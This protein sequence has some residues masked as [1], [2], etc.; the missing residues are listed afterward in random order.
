MVAALFAHDEGDDDRALQ[1]LDTARRSCAAEGNERGLLKAGLLQAGF[2]YENGE[3]GRA[4]Q[5]WASLLPVAERLRDDVERARILLNRGHCARR[6]Q[7]YED[8]AR[9]FAAALP[10]FHTCGMDGEAQKIVWGVA[11]IARERGHLEAALPILA[12]ARNAFVARGM[13]L[14][15]GILSLDMLDLL[16]LAGAQHRVRPLAVELVALFTDAHMPA[17]MTRV[18]AH[19]V[20]E[21]VT[22]AMIARA[23][24][25]LRRIE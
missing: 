1:F 16:V 20:R 12:R 2:L 4:D 5:L 8:A 21:R 11:S 15:A 9:L 13:I 22:R 14:E 10:L 19:L 25:S 23:R 24:R 7:R 18:V 3:V 6:Q 17:Q